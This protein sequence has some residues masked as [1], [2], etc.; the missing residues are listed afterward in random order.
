MLKALVLVASFA[1]EHACMTEALYHE[2]RGE[3]YSG[4][5]KVGAVIKNRMLDDRFPNTICGVVNQPYQFSYVNELD[6]LAMYEKDASERAASAA[7]SILTSGNESLFGNELYFHATWLTPYWADA[8]IATVE[9][10]NHR[11]YTE[12]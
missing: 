12:D 5:I 10:G 8:M 6:D 2:A 7:Y 4:M 11:F 9:I 1:T 3:P